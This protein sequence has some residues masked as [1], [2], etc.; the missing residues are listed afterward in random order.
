VSSK[1]S[2]SGSDIETSSGG[3]SSGHSDRTNSAS[4]GRHGQEDHVEDIDQRRPSK[5]QRK[6]S[7]VDNPQ[8]AGE[9]QGSSDN[10]SLILLPRTSDPQEPVP[11]LS[12]PS[13]L[14]DLTR[15]TVV[16]A[17]LY[18]DGFGYRRE[19]GGGPPLRYSPHAEGVFIFRHQFSDGR[20]RVI[21]IETNTQ[22]REG[23]N[24]LI[25]REQWTENQY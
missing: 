1:S 4:P 19:C 18:F 20:R 8:D 6:S 21:Q 9:G 7:T 24:T 25:V 11:P 5:R 3:N 17:Y 15:P 2:E 22:E 16:S 23:V 13:S 14:P 12:T 10:N